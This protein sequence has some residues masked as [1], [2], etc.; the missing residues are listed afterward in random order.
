MRKPTERNEPR[1]EFLGEQDGEPERALK[2]VLAIE[3]AKFP[4]VER[5]YLAQVGF[6]PSAGVGVALC[7]TPSTTKDA[8]IVQHVG[9][10]FAAQF[11]RDAHLDVVFVDGE[12]ETD[13]QRVCR[14]FYT[15]V[16]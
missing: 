9:K 13:L 1:L 5:A 2:T 15:T 12:Q 14:P 3:L 7:L 16:E 11:S 4:E 8:A 10:V 6:A